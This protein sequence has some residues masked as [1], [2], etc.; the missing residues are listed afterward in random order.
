MSTAGDALRVLIVQHEPATP[1]GLIGDWLDQQRADIDTYRI[2][3]EDRDVDPTDYE[4][5]VSLGSEH[6]AYDDRLGFVASEMSLLREAID[7]SVPILGICFG[8]QLLARV[9]GGRV[10]RAAK[11]EIGWMRVRSNRPELVPAGPWFQWHFDAFA[12]P[13]GAALIAESSVGPQAFVHQRCLGLQF[14]PE[15]TPEIVAEWVEDSAHDLDGQNVDTEALLRETA[16]RLEDTRLMT[17]RLL[18][19]YVETVADVRVE[20]IRHRRAAWGR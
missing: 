16:E 20:R 4:L 2:D 5:I 9:L 10:F 8:G 1:A 3:I 17:W 7:K 15:V 6:A 14:H 11:P 18:Q 19:G 12:T 13:P